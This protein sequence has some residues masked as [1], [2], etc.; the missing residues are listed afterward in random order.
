MPPL[1]PRAPRLATNAA[2]AVLR[3]AVS[4][5]ATPV[6]RFSVI[7]TVAAASGKREAALSAFRVA[8]VIDPA[9]VLPAE[10]GPVAKKL[11]DE[12]RKTAQKQG[13]KLE[14]TAE[15]PDRG[16]AGKGFTVK[17]K[18]PQKLQRQIDGAAPAPKKK[19]A[20]KSK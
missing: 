13:G 15:A 19:K 18:L 10:S 14:I 3:A 5:T 7:G 16:D 20:R 9:F 6:V 11:Y 2:D 12:A 4:T 1:L 8:A 17:A